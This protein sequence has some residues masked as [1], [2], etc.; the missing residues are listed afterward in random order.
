MKELKNSHHFYLAVLIFFL[1]ITAQTMWSTIHGDGAVYAWL[2]REI[3][4][5]G[6]SLLDHPLAWTRQ[7]FFIEHPYFFFYFG[8]LFTKVFGT[9]DIGIKIPNY[10][11]G[12]LSLYMVYKTSRIYT[13]SYWPGI[14]AGYVLITNPLYEL[15]LKQPTL[16][17][18]AQLLSL[19][20]IFFLVAVEKPNMK[21][22]FFS[23][24]LMGLAFLTKGLE[25]LPNL[26]ALFILVCIL[27]QRDHLN[28]F[29]VLFVGLLG[30]TLPLVAWIIY[31]RIFWD[32]AWMNQYFKHQIQ[33]RF[34]GAENTQ[35]AISSGY[36]KNLLAKYF[37][38]MGIIVWGTLKTIKQGRPLGL[39]WWTT[40]I[41]AGFNILAFS[42][43]KK[44]S[45]QHLTGIF[46]FSSV[47]VG[48]YIYEFYQ[49]MKES[50]AKKNINKILPYFHYTLAVGVLVMWVWFTTHK[51]NKNDLWTFIKT[52]TEFLN[53]PE[54]NLPVVLLDDVD[55][56]T[57]I[58]FTAQWYWPTHKIYFAS[59][60]K[61][62]LEPQE[63]FLITKKDANSFNIVRA[64][65]NR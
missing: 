60:A 30:M 10:T 65:Y 3:S 20:S 28:V 64:V 18:L 23:G 52:Q 45:S 31:D 37:I 26:A 59:E 42:I 14:L 11:V 5:N 36:L 1:L 4:L 39:F 24:F 51:N 49:S 61:N 63:V 13:A 57:G 29:K 33:E 43:I 44:D 56:L 7:S 54:N 16:D 22:F 21:R 53:Q 2:I 35:T 58:Y 40:V 8:S 27:I 34:F 46:L 47:L 41:Y 48:Q 9:G 6:K 17:P 32:Q 50:P 15:M 38:Q 12:F 55:D 62:L 25:L 19:L